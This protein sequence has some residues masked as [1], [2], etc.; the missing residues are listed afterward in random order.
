MWYLINIGT[1]NIIL[2]IILLLSQKISFPEN[3]NFPAYGLYAYSEGQLAQKTRNMQFTGAP[4]IF[5]PGNAG[6]Y[7]QAR[8]LASVALRK[9]IDNGLRHH[10]DYFTGM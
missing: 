8:S 10:L 5:V 6:S 7:K 3:D 4:V 9:G 2:N 1:K